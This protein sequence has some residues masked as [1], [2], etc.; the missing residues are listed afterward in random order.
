MIARVFQRTWANPII[1]ARQLSPS[2]NSAVKETP[3]LFGG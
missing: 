2:L 3:T 1:I